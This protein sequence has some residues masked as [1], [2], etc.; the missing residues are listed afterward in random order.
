MTANM[1]CEN[2]LAIENGRDKKNLYGKKIM[3][4]G[5]SMQV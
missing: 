1:P 5:V 2:T 3:Q 4:N